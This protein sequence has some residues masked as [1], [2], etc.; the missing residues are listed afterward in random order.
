MVGGAPLHVSGDVHLVRDSHFETAATQIVGSGPL[1]PF[2]C[3]L[4]RTLGER[5]PCMN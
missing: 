4:R 2:A 1:V 5:F 3:N